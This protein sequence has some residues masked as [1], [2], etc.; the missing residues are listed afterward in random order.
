MAVATGCI[1]I[2]VPI[3]ALEERYPGG[4]KAYERD[5]PNQTFC[6]DE[7]LTRVGF[8]GPQDVEWFVNSLTER[9]AL[10]LQNDGSFTDIAVVDSVFGPTAPC[11]CSSWARRTA[12]TN[13][14]WPAPSRESS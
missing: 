13:V 10:V 2:I 14:G 9:S 5:C 1:S 3:R 7:H 4:V 11:P 12:G 8:M 6:R